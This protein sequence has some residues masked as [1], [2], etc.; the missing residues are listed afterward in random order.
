MAMNYFL[1]LFCTNVM[2]RASAV[3]RR[4]A[5]GIRDLSRLA[6]LNIGNQ[7]KNRILENWLGRGITGGILFRGFVPLHRE[8]R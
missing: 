2:V 7:S 6:L 5:A 8:R 1:T 3:N 4:L